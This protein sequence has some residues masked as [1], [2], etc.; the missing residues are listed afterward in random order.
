MLGHTLPGKHLHLIGGTLP[1][2][3]WTPAPKSSAR[4]KEPVTGSER[5]PSRLMAGTELGAGTQGTAVPAQNPHGLPLVQQMQPRGESL[6]CNQM[7]THPSVFSP[8]A[9]GGA[10]Q[11]AGKL[12]PKQPWQHREASLIHKGPGAAAETQ[13]CLQERR[14]CWEPCNCTAGHPS[15]CI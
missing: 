10:Q 13:V 8:G 14:K 12:A 15:A 5:A 3:N 7:A 1:M 9:G 11:K 4:R 2:E 6:L